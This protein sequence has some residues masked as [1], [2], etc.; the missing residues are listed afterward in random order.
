[1]LLFFLSGD[2]DALEVAW[3]VPSESV[4]EPVELGEVLHL[5][6]AQASCG[7][8]LEVEAGRGLVNPQDA[9]ER[10]PDLNGDG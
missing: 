10:L 6:R 5:R 2:R 1:M 8:R 7:E 9:V 3:V 4:A